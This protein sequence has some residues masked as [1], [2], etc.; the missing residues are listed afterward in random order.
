MIL[1]LL[2]V[3]RKIPL[4]FKSINIGQFS[5]RSKHWW[6]CYIQ[7]SGT[8]FELFSTK[9]HSAAIERLFIQFCKISPELIRSRHCL[10][11]TLPTAAW[12]S[13]LIVGGTV[14]WHLDEVESFN[15]TSDEEESFDDT[16]DE[17]ANSSLMTKSYPR[18]V[19]FADK[20]HFDT[21]RDRKTWWANSGSN[22]T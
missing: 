20:F 10:L 19:R 13:Y 9:K 2:F 5:Q 3:A 17:V 16:S 4:F 7:L 11:L 14:R 21:S 1:K 22:E 8:A 18:S 6:F 12:L 15:D